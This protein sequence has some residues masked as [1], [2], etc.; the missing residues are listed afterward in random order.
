MLVHDDPAQTP[1]RTLRYR[2]A[3]VSSDGLGSARDEPEL[4]RMIQVRQ[5]LYE[6][7]HSVATT[8]FLLINFLK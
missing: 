1:Q 3:V 4:R 6:C 8:P 7:E 5:C 2:H